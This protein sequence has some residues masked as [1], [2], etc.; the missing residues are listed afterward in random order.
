LVE[1]YLWAEYVKSK[2]YSEKAE[3]TKKTYLYGARRVP[4]VDN[5]GFM[6]DKIPLDAIDG[7]AARKLFEV[8]ERDYGKFNS[9][10]I[11]Q[12]MRLIY[13]FG[14]H[15][16]RPP[17]F[18]GDNPFEGMRLK[19][20]Q[21][22]NENYPYEHVQAI[23][24]AAKAAGEEGLALAVDLNYYLTQRPGDLCRLRKSMLGRDYID[25]EEHYFLTFTPSKTK[26]H[27]TI[28]SLPVPARFVPVIMAK[29]DYIITKPD[30]RPY[31]RDSLQIAFRTICESLGLMGYHQHTI[32][33]SS[34]T[35]Y[36]EA[37]VAEAAVAPIGGWKNT[38][39]LNKV[40]KA[41]TKRLTLQALK[42]RLEMEHRI[43]TS[44]PN[45][46]NPDRVN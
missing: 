45:P 44:Q 35:A 7:L 10:K 23:I 3:E 40:Y 12:V 29:E 22:K 15:E 13:N 2:S 38:E 17:I 25:G 37:G 16:F 27:G 4:E 43:S 1:V 30:G 21:P 28:V 19:Q 42:T 6:L 26:K 11:I 5:G 33:N 14:K 20:I 39:M 34:A 46:L 8:L 32:R 36:L 31:T 18:S 41:S 9:R 24:K